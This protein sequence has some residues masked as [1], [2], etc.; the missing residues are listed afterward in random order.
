ME[1]TGQ[2]HAVGEAHRGGDVLL[3]QEQ[4]LPGV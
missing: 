3:D 1:H 2:L 4:R